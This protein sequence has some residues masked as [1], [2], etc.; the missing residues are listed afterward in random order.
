MGSGTGKD[1]NLQ[2][3]PDNSFDRRRDFSDAHQARKSTRG[4]DERAAARLR[5]GLADHRTRSGAGAGT[6]SDPGRARSRP[7]RRD[8][9]IIARQIPAAQGRPADARRAGRH[10]R[11]RRHGLAAVARRVAARGPARAARAGVDA[12]PPAASG[13]IRGRPQVRHQVRLHAE[14]R[15]ARRDQGAGRR[16]EAQRPHPGSSWRDRIGQDLHHGQG[17]RGDPAPGAGARAEQDARRAALRRVQVV[18]PRQRRRVFRLVLRLLPA[19]SL[20][21]AH[22]HLYREGILDQRADRPH[23]PL[24]DALAARARRRHHRRLGVVHLRYRLGRDLFG[25]DLHAQAGRQ[26]QPAPVARRPDRAAIQALR[27][28]F[29]PRL[30]PRA[31]RHDRHLPGAL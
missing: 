5:R 6:R 8:H 7:A 30:V 23:A 20:R 9:Q 21:P 26:D 4:F 28:R 14:G 27:R 22:R 1:S 12:A 25:D 2:P 29:L 16:R 3:P 19:G 15:P 31:R 13:E 17:D 24:G 10:G 18:L 11:V